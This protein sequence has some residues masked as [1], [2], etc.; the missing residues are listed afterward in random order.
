MGKF[1]RLYPIYLVCLLIYYFVI[2]SLHA[3]PMWSIYVDEQVEQCNPGIWRNLL[4]IDNM[5]TQG[6]YDF[7][8]YVQAELQYSMFAI[9]VFFLFFIHR[10]FASIFLYLS[11]L[12]S[13]VLMFVFSSKLPIELE[14]TLGHQNVHNMKMFQTHLPFYLTG[15]VLGML[16]KKES[17]KK[18]IISY[19]FKNIV[20][21]GLGTV[22]SFVIFGLIL[23]RPATFSYDALELQLSLSRV[24]IMFSCLLWF[25]PGM[26]K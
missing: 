25:L 10:S 6:C 16:F 3:G 13:Y 12:V 9:V 20:L 17:T 21:F 4:L 7:S 15:I 2:P 18:I 24:G 8:W 23:F 1:T 5:F 11:L 19:Y 22:S 26:V 14:I